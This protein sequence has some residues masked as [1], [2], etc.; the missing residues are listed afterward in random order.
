MRSSPCKFLITC[1]PSDLIVIS[2]RTT[3]LLSV[4][5]FHLYCESFYSE[6]GRRSNP[7][8]PKPPSLIRLPSNQSVLSAPLLC[9][10]FL[11]PYIFSHFHI[12][13]LATAR[14]LHLLER[15]AYIFYLNIILCECY[16]QDT[17]GYTFGSFEKQFC[18]ARVPVCPVTKE[19]TLL[20]ADTPP[21][22]SN[23]SPHHPILTYLYTTRI[24]LSIDTSLPIPTYIDLFRPFSNSSTSTGDIPVLSRPH[25][26]TLLVTLQ[27]SLRPPSLLPLIVP[28][29]SIRWPIPS[30]SHCIHSLSESN[31]I[32][33]T[34]VVVVPGALRI[35][36]QSGESI[37]RFNP[38][39]H[40][41][42]PCSHESALYTL[43]RHSAAGTPVFGGCRLR[44]CALGVTWRKSN[45]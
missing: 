24:T 9:L 11:P 13:Q 21:F 10:S 34:V 32:R 41:R 8:L 6:R 38:F 15:I 12:I 28:P 30:F 3:P 22:H 7:V 31:A 36:P 18:C 20:E 23:P 43:L 5:R 17:F 19:G 4:K 45:T 25:T 33:H 27:L 40:R 16:R 37:S 2:T 14:S 35:A 39:V 26:N 44:L 42:T 1:V 29:C